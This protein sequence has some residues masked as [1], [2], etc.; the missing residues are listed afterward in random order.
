MGFETSWCMFECLNVGSGRVCRHERC[1]LENCSWMNDFF[2]LRI[3][4]VFLC[5]GRK[6]LTW[7]TAKQM[8]ATVW[9][10]PELNHVFTIAAYWTVPPVLRETK[11]GFSIHFERKNVIGCDWCILNRD[12]RGCLQKHLGVHGHLLLDIQGGFCADPF[13]CRR[14]WERHGFLSAGSHQRQIPKEVG[15]DA[16]ST[17]S[18]KRQWLLKTLVEGIGC[19]SA[20]VFCV[21]VEIVD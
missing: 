10:G 1:N 17:V 5:C 13:H 14:H 7:W 15:S 8:V 16:R 3:L 12:D 9:F 20:E 19:D 11:P 18:L 21:T 6:Y 4:R 2:G